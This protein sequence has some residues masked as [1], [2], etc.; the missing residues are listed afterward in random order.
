M[1]FGL[2]EGGPKSVAEENNKLSNV[3]FSYGTAEDPQ[4]Q[5]VAPAGGLKPSAKQ[6]GRPGSSLVKAGKNG[7][8]TNIG[9]LRDS[10]AIGH[11][12]DKK[13][14]T[15]KARGLVKDTVD[16]RLRKSVAK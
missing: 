4:M 9:S 6:G 5:A 2:T 15:P 10:V 1:F 11:N 8:P 3:Y 13:E 12:N 16:P 7:D 14:L